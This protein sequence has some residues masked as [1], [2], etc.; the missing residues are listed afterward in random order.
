M[1]S[2]AKNLVTFNLLEAPEL[3]DYKEYKKTITF[4]WEMP[5]RA[6]FKRTDKVPKI[7]TKGVSVFF[8]WVSTWIQ[9][10]GV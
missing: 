3:P 1:Q 8:Y 7:C 6:G 5:K 9:F 2:E 4:L 10:Q